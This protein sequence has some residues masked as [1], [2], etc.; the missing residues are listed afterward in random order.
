[1]LNSRPLVSLAVLA[2]LTLGACGTTNKAG[3][4]SATNAAATPAADAGSKPDPQ[5]AAPESKPKP[6]KSLKDRQAFLADDFKIIRRVSDL[7]SAI[8]FMY[9]PEVKASSGM[10]NPG[11]EFQATD[12][13]SKPHLPWRRLI[14]AGIAGDHVFVYHEHGGLAANTQLAF[15]QVNSDGKAVTLWWA[16]CY[17]D[18]Q[19]LDGLRLLLAKG[20]CSTVTY[21]VRAP[22]QPLP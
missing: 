4:A 8:Q 6:L 3:P 1:M 10:A 14:F 2:A 7:P 17:P 20:R 21:P 11:E 13:I 5:T 15:F 16:Y 12:F 9:P 19:N 22:S 18:A